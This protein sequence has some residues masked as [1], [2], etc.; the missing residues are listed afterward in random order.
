MGRPPRW[1]GLPSPPRCFCFGCRPAPAYHRSRR[2][3]RRDY[4][5]QVPVQYQGYRRM[6]A[7]LEACFTAW[8]TRSAI[9][10]ALSDARRS[11]IRKE[12]WFSS[13]MVL[14]WREVKA[15]LT[16]S[17][18]ALRSSRLRTPERM[19]VI[20]RIL[21]CGRWRLPLRARASISSGR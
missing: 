9:S 12:W 14:S 18:I 4:G 7:S 17:S 10:L 8:A 3:C 19:S 20:K 11:T 13:R 15:L 1:S 2:P 21:N 16:I 5:F 6:V